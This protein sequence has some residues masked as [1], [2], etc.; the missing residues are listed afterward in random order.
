MKFEYE[1]LEIGYTIPESKHKYTPDFILPNGI[2]VEAKGKWDYAS[3][4]KMLLV[5][6]QN[7]H[8]DIRMLFMRASNKIRKG[9]PTSYA[10][11]CE[12]NNIKW[13]QGP[14][15]PKEWLKK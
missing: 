13:A 4:K 10:D 14:E 2:I 1:T 7:P 6:A 15:V 3:R 8:L 11:F 9:S 5:I 12:K